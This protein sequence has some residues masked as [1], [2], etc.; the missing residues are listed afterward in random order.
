MPK[1]K[2]YPQKE[3]SH[4]VEQVADEKERIR[5]QQTVKGLKD[6]YCAVACNRVAAT[7][8]RPLFGSGS[9]FVL[10]LL[11]NALKDGGF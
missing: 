10:S 8:C 1:L 4:P 7:D 6:M 5:I 11:E 2:R 3:A 9:R